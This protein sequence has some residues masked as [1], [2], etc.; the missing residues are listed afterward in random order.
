MI[1]ILVLM[2]LIYLTVCGVRF[3]SD[4]LSVL[5]PSKS[6]HVCVTAFAVM[7]GLGGFFSIMVL[8]QVDPLVDYF[9]HII[10]HAALR[11]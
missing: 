8:A 4:S 6:W 5:H 7:V 9:S 11:E 10:F 2:F 1:L 3:L